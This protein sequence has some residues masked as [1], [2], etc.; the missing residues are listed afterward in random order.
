M[1][2]VVGFCKASTQPTFNRSEFYSGD[3]YD[4]H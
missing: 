4:G 1:N 2:R 3:V